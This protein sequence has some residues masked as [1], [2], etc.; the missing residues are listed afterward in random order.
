MAPDFLPL[1]QMYVHKRGGMFRNPANFARKE[2][3][4]E[5]A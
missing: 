5:C 4:T 2:N 1:P 3:Q